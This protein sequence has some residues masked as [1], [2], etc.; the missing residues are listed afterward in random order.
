[1]PYMSFKK[2]FLKMEINS[3]VKKLSKRIKDFYSYKYTFSVVSDFTSFASITA[4]QSPINEKPR[5]LEVI[6]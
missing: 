2:T 4:E 6:Q 5:R 3:I 1:M